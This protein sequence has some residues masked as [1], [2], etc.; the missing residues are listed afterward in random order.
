MPNTAV[1]FAGVDLTDLLDIS[2][3]LLVS[4]E[5]FIQKDLESIHEQSKK[6]TQKTASRGDV[7]AKGD[8][9]LAANGFDV[10]KYRRLVNKLDLKQAFEPLEPIGETDIEGYLKHEH[11]MILLS[12]IEES[13]RHTSNCFYRNYNNYL[14]KD[15]N[16]AKDELNQILNLHKSFKS[17]TIPMTVSSGHPLQRKVLTYQP[18]PYLQ[19]NILQSPNTPLLQTPNVSFGKRGK[20]NMDSRMVEYSNVVFDFNQIVKRNDFYPILSKF[21]Q[22]VNNLDDTEIRKR[23]VSECW[24]LLI[25][26]VN[27]ENLTEINL[28]NNSIKN[29]KKLI[30]GVKKYMEMA[31]VQYMKEL[32]QPSIMGSNNYDTTLNMSNLD[33]VKTFVSKTLSHVGD[34]VLGEFLNNFPI[35]PVLFYCLRC[36]FIDEAISFVKECKG[37][38]PEN[39]LN[40]LEVLKNPNQQPLTITNIEQL[41]NSLK[42]TYRKISPT[43]IFQISCYLVLG[44][45]D[46]KKTVPQVFSKTEDFMWLKLSF[47]RPTS[48]STT[49]ATSV[50]SK[51][52][53]KELQQIVVS[54]GPKHFSTRKNSLLYFKLL[55]STLQ[56]ERAIEYLCGRQ[57]EGYQVEA[58]HFAFAL[59]YYGLL[60]TTK[61]LT[62]PLLTITNDLPTLNFYF[63]I[64]DYVRIFAHTNPRDAISY[65]YIFYYKGQKN[66]YFKCIKELVLES[67]DITVLL[68]RV[69][70]NGMI[71]KGC[72]EQY[73]TREELL[74]ILEECANNYKETGRYRDAVDLFFMSEDLYRTI[75]VPIHQTGI[76]DKSI[77]YF[78]QVLNIMNDELTQVL[79]G[80]EN[81]EEVRLLAGKVN[82]KFV[83]NTT[84]LHKVKSSKISNLYE[85][86]CL[87]LRLYEVF[88]L[89]TNRNYEQALKNLRELNVIP[90]DEKEVEGKSQKF[91]ELDERIQR[92]ISD[93]LFVAMSILS[94]LYQIGSKVNPPQELAKM[95]RAVMTFAG[96]H[97]PQISVQVYETLIKYQNK[98]QI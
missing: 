94:H 70:Q 84:I 90:F 32:I 18:S 2:Q 6:L 30:D 98:M 85:T 36:G 24:K 81:R 4:P 5:N 97:Q 42:E 53:L 29:E 11:D 17:G 1:G 44:R 23:E 27:E 83:T 35:W 86:F 43:K 80:G 79:S 45:C 89:F 40:S 63:L 75:A 12:S 28:Q 65:F 82:A 7:Q 74:K 50:S 10:E 62:L 3:Q 67:N 8:Y 88:D 13:K 25:R 61:E 46:V 48:T 71:K 39:I 26:M 69:E 55:L 64:R 66:E 93:I 33:L 15:W 78:R 20:T 37:A 92:K 57:S 14:E 76:T 21:L 38:F 31:Y 60:N 51:Y 91:K 16:R 19:S 54:H 22:V 72:L 9:L 95:S 47:I 87:L 73:L 77:E 56:F 49:S 96:F 59:N 68:G 52:S 41:E 34:D 58:I